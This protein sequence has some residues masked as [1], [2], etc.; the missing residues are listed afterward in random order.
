[1]SILTTLATKLNPAGIM[2]TVYKWLAILGIGFALAVAGFFYGKHDGDEESK[3][4]ISQY[5]AKVTA[6]TNQLNQVLQPEQIQVVTKYVTQTIHDQQVGV[7]NE[8]A[9]T[10]LVKEVP[11]VS[12]LADDVN[13]FLSNGWVS[14]YNS[15]TADTTVSSAAA[16][17]GAAS[18]FTAIDALRNDTT[19]YAICN[20]YKA[21]IVTLQTT[22]NDYN[23]G[24]MKVNAATVK[25]K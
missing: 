23:A 14:T 19:N 4:A 24:V 6:I 9:A 17:D 8:K 13:K 7:D 2:T 11:P 10:Q 5:A 20:Q 12:N 22:I 25:K 1:M 16:S 18:T 21:T 3:V 15:A